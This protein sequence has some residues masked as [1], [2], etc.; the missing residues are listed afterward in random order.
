[1]E[2]QSQ[3]LFLSSIAF[4]IT[5]KCNFRCRHC[6]NSS[7]EHDLECCEISDEEFLKVAEDIVKISPSQVC[8]CGGEPLMK[9]DLLCKVAKTIRQNPSIRVNTVTNGYMMTPEIARELKEAGF[10]SVQISL[11]G[12]TKE[13]HE[14]LRNH[15]GSFERAK[16]AI[17][18]LRD[19]G[20]SPGVACCPTK[21][22]LDEILEVAELAFELGSDTFRV[23]PIM[24]L[25]RAK[26]IEDFFPTATDYMKL[27][28]KIQK[29]RAENSS[30]SKFVEWGD[31]I[32]HL[33]SMKSNLP[34]E[35]AIVNAYGEILISPYVPISFGNTT[36]HP[37]SEYLN[38]GFADIPQIKVVNKIINLIQSPEQMDLHKTNSKLPSLYESEFITIDLIEDDVTAKSE[39]YIKSLGL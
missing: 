5:Y 19:A 38:H 9:K 36:R 2:N 37:L 11:D 24:S 30:L 14:W 3:K 32:A 23:Q 28:R 17:R 26:A 13:S 10:Y 21:R 6:Y 4:D 22:N 20:L 18:Y 16:N 15:D 31:P 1:M 8:V 33:Y 25:G 12:S 7:G 27:S 34:L 39:A 35:A 29:L